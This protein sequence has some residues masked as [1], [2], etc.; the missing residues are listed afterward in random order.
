[1]LFENV[2]REAHLASAGSLNLAVPAVSDANKV[3]RTGM[4]NLE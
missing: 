1:V 2:N 4:L 3:L